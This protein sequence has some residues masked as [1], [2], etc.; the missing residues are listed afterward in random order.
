MKKSNTPKSLL[1]KVLVPGVSIKIGPAYASRGGFEAGQIIELEHGIFEVD[2]GYGRTEA[3]PSIWNESQ[4]EFDSI[5]HLFGNDLDEMQ[6]CEILG[7][8]GKK[9]SESDPLGDRL[10]N[11]QSEV[12]KWAV[13]CF[14]QEVCD[15]HVER[16]QRFAEE[17]IETIQAFGCTEEEVMQVVRYV[18]KRPAGDREQE[19]G[20]AM[21]TMAT[22]CIASNIDMFGCALKELARVKQP[23]TLLKIRAKQ[24]AK[25][26]F[27]PRLVS[28]ETS[29][30]IATI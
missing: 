12:R 15:D 8:L 2:D 11:F 6:D 5:F 22:L 27:L 1:L 19:I 14:G 30:Q 9:E 13:E 20:G 7:V 16:N 26:R 25:P 4:K 24:A 29:S 17:A 28:A 10:K 23:G 18:F 3:A 21:L